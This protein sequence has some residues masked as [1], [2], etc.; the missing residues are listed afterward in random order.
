MFTDMELYKEMLEALDTLLAS[1]GF[2]S[3]CEK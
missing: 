3:P 2:I 1:L